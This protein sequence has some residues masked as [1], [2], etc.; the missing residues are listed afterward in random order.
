MSGPLTRA[1][2]TRLE[3]AAFSALILERVSAPRHRGGP[4]GRPADALFAEL[5]ESGL[6]TLGTA[7]G[8]SVFT[9][10]RVSVPADKPARALLLD[11]RDKALLR[12]ADLHRRAAA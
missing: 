12:A 9:L 7:G 10:A 11:W 3:L 4:S 2:A 1:N 5:V 6:A 8:H